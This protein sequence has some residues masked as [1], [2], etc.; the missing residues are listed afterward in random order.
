MLPKKEL[1]RHLEELTNVKNEA[2]ASVDEFSAWW[3]ELDE[4]E[5][6]AVTNAIQAFENV[7]SGDWMAAAA[8]G[9]A[10]EISTRIDSIH[11]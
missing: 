7:S 1:A 10:S 6:N 4:S 11:K 8:K 5:R 2:P 3:E 9:T